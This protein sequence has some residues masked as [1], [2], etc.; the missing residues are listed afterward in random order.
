M[1]ISLDLSSAFDCVIHTKLLS[2][3]H[4]DFGIDGNCLKWL[5]SYLQDRSQYVSLMNARSPTTLLQTGVPQGSVLA[6]LLFSSYV[7]PITRLAYQHGLS[8]HSY[9]DDTTI[10]FPLGCNTDIETKLNALNICTTDLKNWLMF[11]G[12]MPNPNK[13]DAIVTGTKQQV[14]RTDTQ[15]SSIKIAD[16]H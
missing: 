14:H 13:T 16:V 3:L 5:K 6:P 10:Y 11:Q 8:C 12:L 1:L 15:T 7:S 2:R 9:A 4:D